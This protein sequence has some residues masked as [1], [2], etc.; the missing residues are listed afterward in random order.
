V[1]AG[2]SPAFDGVCRGGWGSPFSLPAPVG[3]KVHMKPTT[4]IIVGDCRAEDMDNKYKVT[5]TL[6]DVDDD[7]RINVEFEPDVPT[8]EVMSPAVIFACRVIEQAS[9]LADTKP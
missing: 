9:S 1:T 6:E 7:L 4:N 5:I 3:R 2:N 8:K